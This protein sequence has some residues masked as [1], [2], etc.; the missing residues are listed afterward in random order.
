MK[1]LGYV[2]QETLWLNPVATNSTMQQVTKDT[3]FSWLSMKADQRIIFNIAGQHLN[4]NQWQRPFEFLTDRF[5]PNHELSRTPDGKNA[6]P[7]LL[8]TF[9]R[10]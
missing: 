3:K 6:Q 4:G 10:W 1:I 2:L 7:L 5:D 8:A 9:T